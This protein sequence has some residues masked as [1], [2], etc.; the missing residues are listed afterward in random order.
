MSTRVLNE[1][2]GGGC[3]NFDDYMIIYIFFYLP[4]HRAW[5]IQ[6]NSLIHLPVTG[7]NIYFSSLKVIKMKE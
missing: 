5:L 3:L 7:Q 1:E 2:L 6:I 4:G